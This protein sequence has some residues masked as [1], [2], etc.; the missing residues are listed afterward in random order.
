[1]CVCEKERG[2]ARV[3]R[4]EG[5]MEGVGVTG[6]GVVGG[7][8]THAH[9][10]TLPPPPPLLKHTPQDEKRRAEH[11]ARTMSERTIDAQRASAPVPR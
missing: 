10:H 5:G 3:R 8:S 7:P 2:W 4:R 11:A 9:P 1:L 6:R